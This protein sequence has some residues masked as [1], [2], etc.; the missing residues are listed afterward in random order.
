[1]QNS[2][3]PRESPR[4]PRWD[5]HSISGP[6]L[7]DTYVTEAAVPLCLGF[8]PRAWHPL[9]L[10][11]WRACCPSSNGGA[12]R[13]E[14]WHRGGGSRRAQLAEDPS[15]GRALTAP[16]TGKARPGV[17]YTAVSFRVPDAC[18]PLTGGT[19][20]SP[21]PGQT[22][23]LPPP[24]TGLSSLAY[25]APGARTRSTHSQASAPRLLSP[26]RCSLRPRLTRA[27][28]GAGERA[29]GFSQ[30]NGVS[31]RAEV[32]YLFLQDQAL[33]LAFFPLGVSCRG[34]GPSSW[35][36]TCCPGS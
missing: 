16:Q 3:S 17:C 36:P 29:A 34:R 21:P 32:P 31:G 2:K 18:C 11:R 5:N 19:A 22:R 7:G 6:L 14:V 26:Q 1:M 9:Q 33:A 23:A 13:V 8:A 10:Q 20:Q 4:R 12:E 28:P 15:K 27:A 24:G 35:A 25:P 30:R